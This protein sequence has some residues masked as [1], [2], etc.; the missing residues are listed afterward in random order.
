M[1][2]L[3]TLSL[4]LSGLS[5]QTA[6]LSEQDAVTLALAANPDL[7]VLRAGKVVAEAARLQ[8]RALANPGIKFGATDF[9]TELNDPERKRNNVA[10]TW[11]P[12]RIGQIA[13]KT[14][15]AQAGIDEAAADIHAAENRLAAE[16]RLL[17]R[18]LC[19]LDEQ[20]QVGEAIAATR[21]RI[22]H[23]V[24]LQV[25][26]GVK[27][28][29]DRSAAEM[30]LAE[31]RQLVT[32]YRAERQLHALRL[33]QKTGMPLTQSL[34]VKS[35][36]DPFTLPQPA[37]HRDTLVA[38]ATAQ[39]AELTAQNARCRGAA[40]AITE[41]RREAYPWI[42]NFQII[43][44]TRRVDS[45]GTWGFQV[46]VEIPVFSWW[47]NQPAAVPRA[48]LN[49]CQLQ[50]EAL[51][52]RITAEVDELLARVNTAAGEL[53]G[54]QQSIVQLSHHQ[55]ETAKAE[56]TAGQADRVE[57]LLAEI[58]LLTVRQVYLAKLLEYRVLEAG[59]QQ[60]TGKV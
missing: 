60:A 48:E 52:A 40:L 22:L 18:T 6:A 16:I 38:E 33:Q 43:R 36:A 3:A 37:F 15:M 5:A 26:A 59:I 46:N 50:T 7:Q 21:T 51:K 19:L 35:E 47:R 42:S 45:P 29:L 1:L 17:H 44:R 58:R 11:A 4:C 23:D 25:E 31:A 27:S 30:A 39:R 10:L 55:I 53:A 28:V 56:L 14:A 32:Q 57:P 24:R 41:A 49:R 2:L 8:A 34:V 13:L 54:Y 20:L 12:P 9:A